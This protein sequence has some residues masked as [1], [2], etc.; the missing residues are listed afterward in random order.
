[1]ETLDYIAQ[2]FQVNIAAR[3]PVEI[4]K[5]NRKIMAET[6]CELGFKVGAEIGVAKGEHS[7][8]LCQN[9]PDLK[10]YCIDAWEHYQGYRDY[11][12]ARLNFFYEETQKVLAPYN[13]VIIK[14]FSMDAVKDF[15]DRSLDFV[16]IDAAHDFRHVV[17]DIDDWSKKVKKGGIIYGHDY[18]RSKNPRLR[19]EVIDAVNGYTY[20]NHIRPWFLLGERGAY[21]RQYREG[22]RSWMWV[23]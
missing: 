9:I 16:Y 22:T 15:E 10:L 4:L 2:K 3:P 13:C 12:T 21:D 11:L 18:K 17:D 20:A 14:K 1:M 19:Q 6:L 8:L 23:C 7:V 5:I